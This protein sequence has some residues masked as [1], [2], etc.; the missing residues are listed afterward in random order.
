MTTQTTRLPDWKVTTAYRILLKIGWA[1]MV[2]AVYFAAAA[3][4]LGATAIWWLVALLAVVGM[5]TTLLLPEPL[6]RDMITGGH[7]DSRGR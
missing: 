1:A 2:L 6:P 4:I 5:L 7:I 3:A